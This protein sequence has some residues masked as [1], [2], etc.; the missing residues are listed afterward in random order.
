MAGIYIPIRLGINSINPEIVVCENCKGE[1]VERE[2][3]LIEMHDH[4]KKI[5][6]VCNGDRVLNRI[7]TI[8]YQRIKINSK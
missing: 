2:G 6:T 3:N 1:G 7:T 8:E 5:C 4:D